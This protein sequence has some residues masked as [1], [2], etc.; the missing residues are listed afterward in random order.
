MIAVP[1]W[2]E[3]E[4]SGPAE[5]TVPQSSA[6]VG[7]LVAKAHLTFRFGCL[8]LVARSD[9]GDWRG[10]ILCRSCDMRLS[11]PQSSHTT[12]I[13]VSGTNARRITAAYL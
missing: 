4:I 1:P 8:I 3:I 9:T 12:G 2:N 13:P 5:R 10:R 7:H 11:S 6:L